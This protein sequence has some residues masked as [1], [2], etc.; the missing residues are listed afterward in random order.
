M[1]VPIVPITNNIVVNVNTAF[2]IRI[3]LADLL[4]L[5]KATSHLLGDT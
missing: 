1:F 2:R 3:T 5:L 4:T